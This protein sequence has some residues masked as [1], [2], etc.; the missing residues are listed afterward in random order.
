[1]AASPH[2]HGLAGVH[3]HVLTARVLAVASLALAG[4]L[5]AAAQQRSEPRLVLSA[6]AGLAGGRHLWSVNRQPLLVLGTEAAPQYDSLLLSRSIRPGLVVGLAGSLF[7]SPSFGVSA[8]IVFLGLSTDDHCTL[9]YENPGADVLGRNAALC[10]DI[11]T[12]SVSPTTVAFLAGA[13]YRAFSRGF[14]SPYVRGQIGIGTRSVSTVETEGAYLD[15]GTLIRRRAVIADVRSSSPVLSAGA[16]LGVM[17]PLSA[18]HLVRLELR[19][20][21]LPMKRVTGVASPLA[22]APTSTVLVHSIALTAGLD[23]VLERSRGRRY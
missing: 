7:R 4:H 20:Q 6:F 16:A 8:E 2:P 11:D 9:T 14:A 12:H 3:V 5:P 10:R 17:V 18:G 23:I 22:I 1:M 21:V 13:T 19:D 15:A